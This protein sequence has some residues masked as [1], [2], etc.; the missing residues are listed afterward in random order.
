MFHLVDVTCSML[1]SVVDILKPYLP[2]DT[3]CLELFARNLQPGWTSWGN[4]VCNVVIEERQSTFR[5]HPAI[6][7]N[8]IISHCTT[9]QYNLYL[10]RSVCVCVCACVRACVSF[11]AYTRRRLWSDRAQIWHTHADSSRNGNGLNK[12]KIRLT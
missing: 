1:H 10:Y 8:Y 4:E 11:W 2:D 12:K 6:H 3:K 7:T 9:L 5:Q